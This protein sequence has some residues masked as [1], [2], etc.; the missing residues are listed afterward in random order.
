MKDLVATV[1]RSGLWQ[2]LGPHG[3]NWLAWTL[4]LA[5]A[6][7]L[8]MHPLAPPALLRLIDWH[9]IGALAGL[10]VLTKGIEC[11]GALQG[12]AQRL[13]MRITGLRALGLLS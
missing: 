3:G 4:L 1:A 6:V 5:A 8:V 2:R 11:S 9:T 7:L 12:A 13:L 10:L